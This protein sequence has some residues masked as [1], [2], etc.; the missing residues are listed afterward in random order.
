[1]LLVEMVSPVYSGVPIAQFEGIV[2]VA[3]HA[4][5]LGMLQIDAQKHLVGHLEHQCRL[6]KREALHHPGQRESMVT[7]KFNVHIK[8]I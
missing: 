3:L 4:S 1:M 7:K 2:R 5:I 6:I 8:G